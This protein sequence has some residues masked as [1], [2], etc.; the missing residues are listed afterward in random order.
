MA[1]GFLKLPKVSPD[2]LKAF[3]LAVKRHRT[4]RGWTLDQLGAE[5]DPPVGKSFISKV[6]KGKKEALSARTVGR[7]INALGLDAD[8]IDR[9]LD[10]EDSA[11]SDETE[12]EQEADR[13]MKAV[14]HDP[15]I[16]Q[17]S[18]D[19]LILLANQHAQGSYTD[20]ITAFVG[21]REAL[22]AAERIR[23]RGEMP[24]GNADSQF[25]A[26]MKEVAQL[27]A[28]GEVDAADALLEAEEKRMLQLHKAERDRMEQQAQLL[29]ERRLDQDRLRDDPAAAADRLI[30]DLHR[31]APAGG[32]VK[33][34]DDTLHEWCRN[35]ERQGD[36]FDLRVALVLA[37]RNF[38]RAKGWQKG[39][40]L[41]S[42]GICRESIGR[43][44]AG[45]EML[46]SA[47]QAYRAALKFMDKKRDRGNWSATLGNL[48]SVLAVI[49]RRREDPVTH[50]EAIACHLKVLDMSSKDNKVEDWAT[51]QRNL[52]SALSGLGALE[53][54]ADGCWAAMEA[55]QAA[56]PVFTSKMTL[57]QRARITVSIAIC[58]RHLARILGDHVFFD[59]AEDAYGKALQI[60]KPDTAPYDWAN[61]VGGLGELAL[62]RFAVDP[63]P[64]LL[65]EA[66]ARLMEA[67]SIMSKSD[68]V[69]NDRIDDLLSKIAGARC[70]LGG[71]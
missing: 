32:I 64:N 25:N 1:P 2:D 13:L 3:G 37:N 20:R 56:L 19:L 60:L 30:R 65:D 55:Y 27:N 42:L 34:T 9:F 66:E 14:A 36:P 43:R 39:I 51:A 53:Q 68:E 69:L 26:V 40:A 61:T 16:P 7:F 57:E 12:T 62:D 45:L 24:A 4:L 11:D 50:R 23:E 54:D 48:G 8:W 67:K 49:G 15:S 44:R 35:G 46:Q 58:Y 33:S 41:N 38:K 28:H 71:T 6:E 18:E 21:L 31:R 63:D 52:G 70:G 29:L 47:E 17:G 59:Q 10:V 5:F 22:R